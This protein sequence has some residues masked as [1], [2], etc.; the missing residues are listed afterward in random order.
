MTEAR[1]VRYC[2][3]PRCPAPD[4]IRDSERYLRI[5]TEAH[6]DLPIT[7][8]LDFCSWACVRRWVADQERHPERW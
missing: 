1:P 2:R 7:I 5:H 4:A 8:V 6:L 3:G